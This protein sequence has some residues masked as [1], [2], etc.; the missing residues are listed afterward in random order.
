MPLNKI[1]LT[2]LL[3]AIVASVAL[4][5]YYWPKVVERTVEIEKEVRKTDIRTITKIVERPDGTKET[6]VD[7]TDRTTKRTDSSKTHEVFE[8]QYIGSLAAISPVQSLEPVYSISL[9]KRV[10]GPFF[11]G[12]QAD[13]SS[14]VGVVL[15]VEF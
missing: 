10:V 4:T 11:I 13:T 8:A 2:V 15:N 14:R 12:L 7:T 3:A 9:S 1:S 5:R 6:V